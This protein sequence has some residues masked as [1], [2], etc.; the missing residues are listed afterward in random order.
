M[1]ENEDPI[2]AGLNTQQIAAV[3][4]P[5]DR[6]CLVL[7]GAGCGKTTVL[8]RRVAYCAANFCNPQHILALTFTHKAAEEMRQRALSLLPAVCGGATQP[9]ITTFHGFGLWVVRDT[10]GGVRNAKRL[11]FFEEPRLLS[12]RERLEM[13]AEISNAQERQALGVDLLGLD[14]MLARVDANPAKALSL[15]TR[16]RMVLDEVAKR[17]AQRKAQRGVW[18]FSDMIAHALDL[19][20]RFPD[21]RDYYARFFRHIVVDEFQDT[22]PQQ[23]HL[24]RHLLGFGAKIFAVGDDDQA[25]YG[26]RGADTGP[27]LNFSCRFDNACIFKLEI[28]YRSRPAILK[29]ANRIFADKP[30][31]YRKILRSGRFG[32]SRSEQGQK[33][34][35]YRF[36]TPEAMLD[37]ILGRIRAVQGG[38]GGACLLFRLNETMEWA[39]EALRRRIPG[40][41]DMP[42]MMTVHGAKGLE[43][44]VVFLCDCEESVF[45][46]YRIRKKNTI[47]SWADVP[48]ILL[49]RR[50]A[51][52]PAC[53]I[54]EERRL[55]YVAVTRAQQALYLL[56]CR[57]KYHNGRIVSFEPSRFLKLVR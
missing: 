44:P 14:D 11:G 43:F 33:P 30:L 40:E 52:P 27:I 20:E 38:A 26:F 35:C 17:F 1:S 47:R 42:V 45:P 39:R 22:N 29:A 49:S 18:E 34:R 56:S 6:H 54:D 53:D 51:V 24:L 23:I 5:F 7:A 50:S 28:N 55:F 37:W 41:A 15:D 46:Y 48:K 25:I 36:S 57:K 16:R 2:F 10:V 21:V 4:A 31:S 3:R 19:F 12:P 9:R 8:T 13:L 32:T